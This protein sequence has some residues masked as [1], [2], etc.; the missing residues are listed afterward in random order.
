M[1]KFGLIGKTLEHSFSPQYFQTKF[2][3][4]EINDASYEL[5][6]LKEDGIAEFLKT[7]DIQ[8][9]NVTFP[10]K[11]AIIEHLDEVDPVAFEIG[12]VNTV[13]RIGNEWK[14]Y[15]TDYLGFKESMKLFQDRDIQKV[16]ILGTGGA[17]KAVIKALEE[18]DIAYNT[19]S[20]EPEEAQWGY[21]RLNETNIKS[22]DIIV[23]TTPLGTYPKVDEF[24]GIP[25][26]HLRQGQILYDLVYNPEVTEFMRKGMRAGCTV[27]NGYEMLVGQADES[28]KIWVGENESAD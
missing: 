8:G 13:K 24:P 6:P 4:E 20:R 1:R 18:L 23:N 2:L 14:G 3:L 12:A 7:T 28:W 21:D 25:Y 9:F 16:L 19:V 5:F 26:E 17:S 10:F 22:F 11:E 27:K 15:N